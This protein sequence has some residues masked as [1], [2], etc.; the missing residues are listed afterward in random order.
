MHIIPERYMSYVEDI[1]QP[2]KQKILDLIHK[3]QKSG[4]IILSGDV[5]WAQ[6]FHTK[7]TSYTGYNLPEICSSGMTHVLSENSYEGI[8][9]IMEGHSPLLYKVLNFVSSKLF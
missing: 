4:V 5:H 3:Y 9:V 1:G 8:D 6:M 7:C 2:A